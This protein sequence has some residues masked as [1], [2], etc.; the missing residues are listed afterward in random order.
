MAESLSQ[1][2]DSVEG[3]R[4]TRGLR[5]IPRQFASF[6]A[7]R[8]IPAA[9]AA[10]I[11][12][13]AFVG[14][15][16]WMTGL[17]GNGQAPPTATSDQ[18]SPPETARNATSPGDPVYPV[19]AIPAEP[20]C[21][22]SGPASQSTDELGSSEI[23]ESALTGVVQILT[24]VGAGTGIVA[25]PA[26]LIVTDSQVVEGSWLIKV[27]LASGETIKG[28]LF[29]I[30]KDTGVAYIE[31]ATDDT[32]T[33]FPLGNS[34]EVCVGDAAFAIGYVNDSPSSGTNPAYTRGRISSVRKDFL[35]TDVSLG[36]GIAGGPLLDSR[37][38]IIGVN[39]AGIVVNGDTATSATN[40]A[41][42]I[43][44]VKQ[45]INDGLDQSKLTTSVR[46]T[47]DS[48]RTP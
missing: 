40:F 7:A 1:V 8:R 31:V 14:V 44:G 23:E 38:R 15:V 6:F 26:G 11:V 27:R 45:E 10:A 41:I 20:E 21:Q 30:S 16:L 24:D 37:G 25:D 36:S 9:I 48:A 2:V 39:S 43:N 47:P 34:D 32:L 28:E 5:G 33:A 19:T 29:G 46:T 3:K 13:L 22:R 35:R 12:A 42:P 4:S 17:F 18:A